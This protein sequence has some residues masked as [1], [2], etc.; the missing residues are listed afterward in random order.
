MDDRNF[1][2]QL[3]SA[4]LTVEDLARAGDLSAVDR[5]TLL[6][7]LSALEGQAH[8]D[9]AEASRERMVA[10]RPAI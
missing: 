8:S 5:R 2:Q 10:S 7:G 6:L 4:R 3:A 9:R 1:E